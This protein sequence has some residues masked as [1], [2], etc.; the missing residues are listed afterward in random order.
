MAFPSFKNIGVGMALKAPAPIPI[1]TPILVGRDSLAWNGN[2][3]ERSLL[4]QWLRTLRKHLQDS[5]NSKNLEALLATHA[6]EDREGSRKQP[7]GDSLSPWSLGGEAFG[8]V[9]THLQRGE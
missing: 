1:P 2:A 5:K 7:F 9:A 3:K 6:A 8:S 4:S